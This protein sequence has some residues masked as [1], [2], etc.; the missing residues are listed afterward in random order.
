MQLGKIVSLDDYGD[1]NAIWMGNE[2][3]SPREFLM[4][5]EK[6]GKGWN[7]NVYNIGGRALK[8]LNLK[9]N[10]IWRCQHESNQF[11]VRSPNVVMITLCI[12]TRST[13]F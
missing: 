2:F 8:T 1:C 11:N 3:V 10:A 7:K 9:G 6:I 5:R 13:A 4:H 12:I